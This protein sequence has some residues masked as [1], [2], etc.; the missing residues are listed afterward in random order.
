M[1]KGLGEMKM[2]RCFLAL[3]IRRLL[4][5]F[6]SIEMVNFKLGEIFV[7]YGYLYGIKC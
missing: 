6:L 3:L 7:F 2:E 5:I 4:V 1:F